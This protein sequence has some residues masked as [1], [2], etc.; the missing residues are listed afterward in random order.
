MDFSLFYFS[1]DSTGN[2]RNRYELLMEGARFADTHDFRAVWTPE[3][4]FHPFGGLYPNP[5]VTGAAVAAVTERVG[6]RAGSVVA[7]THHPARVAEEW[8]VVD[9]LSRGRVGVSFASG[10]SAIDFSF[11]PENYARRRELLFEHTEEIRRLWRGESLDVVDGAGAP[12]RV[13]IFPPPVQAELPVW[14]TSG[15]DI[16][17][18]RGA[19]RI[20]AG[21]LTHL[22]GQDIDDLGK[23][24]EEYRAEY[25][26]ATNGGRGHVALMVH[27]YL[28]E[29]DDE[30]REIVREPL[31]EYLRSSI[32]LLVGSRSVD[33][34]KIDPASLRPA[35]VDFLVQRSFDRYFDES[36]LLG[37]LDKGRRIVERLRGIQVDEIACLIDF[38]LPTADVLN[39]LKYL[40][41][42][43]QY[44]QSP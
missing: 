35:D 29:D 2:E 18:F 20:G 34:R 11:T 19:G 38:G 22:L 32:N 42:L 16:G 6:I 4:H 28:G 17:T 39:G 8:A 25:R 14:I 5:A 40:D 15:G 37:G 23:K 26:A 30:I 10:W 7:P 21:L 31:Y 13:R 27:T 9:N 44:C 36:G 24:I 1:A 12:T 3:R 43:R 41:Q 33:A